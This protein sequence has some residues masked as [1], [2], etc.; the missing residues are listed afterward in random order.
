MPKRR[1]DIERIMR[2]VESEHH[3]H[4]EHHHHHHHSDLGDVIAALEVMI[5]SLAAQSKSFERELRKQGLAIAA[6][7]RVVAWLVEALAADSDEDKRK[8][9]IKALDELRRAFNQ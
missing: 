5:D 9:L 3:Q 4:E 1:D 2:E 7:Y 6:L 8:Y